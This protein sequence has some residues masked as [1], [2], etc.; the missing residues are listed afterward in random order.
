VIAKRVAAGLA[1]VAVVLLVVAEFTTLFE[2]TVGSL[3]VVRRSST[4]GDNHGY[5]LLVIAVVAAGMTLLALRGAR[6]PALA[7]VALAI[8]ALVIALAV[9]LPDTRRSGDLPESLAYENARSHARAGF[10]LEIAGGVLLLAAG[11]VLLAA[12]RRSS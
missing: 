12:G 6:P 9:D 1:L 2:V 5:A 8:A 7:L 10:G 4:G 11:G 3:E